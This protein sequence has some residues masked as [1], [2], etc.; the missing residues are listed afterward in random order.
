MNIFTVNQVNQVYVATDYKDAKMTVDNSVLGDIH[1]G[2]SKEG[3][4]YFQHRG[5]GGLTRSDL[6][7][8]ANIMYANVTPASQMR[9]SKKKVTITLK[10]ELVTGGTINVSDD[11]VLRI[12]F[13]HVTSISPDSQYWKYG[14]VRTV[15]NTTTRSDFYK[16]LA[17]S[18]AKNMSREALKMIDVYVTDNNSNEILVKSGTTLSGT[19]TNIVIKEVEQDWILGLKQQRQIPFTVEPVSIKFNE[20]DFV[21][22]VPSV[23]IDGYIGN[24]KDMA[25][26]E[27]FYMGERGDQYRKINWPNYVP[28]E[29]MVDPTKEYDVISIHYFY[30]GSNH[31]V[32]KSE[33]DIT[34]LVPSG[35]RFSDDNDSSNDKIV[36][37]DDGVTTTTLSTTKDLYV[38]NV[39]I[40]KINFLVGGNLI[41]EI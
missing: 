16:T 37:N 13:D 6:I 24:G 40:K 29:Y 8:A 4:L 12:K 30:N 1:V 26:Y 9:K 33:K 20:A 27:Y 21:W 28:T 36:L 25:D 31:A 7:P 35:A 23:T 34:I 22:G 38:T 2:K 41:Q 17:L 3:D 32:Q 14:V 11:F 15:K 39:I 10:P 18:I 5:K 19:Y